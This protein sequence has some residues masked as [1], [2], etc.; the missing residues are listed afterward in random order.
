MLIAEDT[1]CTIPTVGKSMALGR[2][3]FVPARSFMSFYFLSP[4]N[5]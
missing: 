3:F 2:E 5:V 1:L 4:D